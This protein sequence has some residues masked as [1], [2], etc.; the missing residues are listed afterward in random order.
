MVSLPADSAEGVREGRWERCQRAR[1]EAAE[2]VQQQ[3]QQQTRR[4][5]AYVFI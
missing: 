2:A 5:I 3:G 4:G 1:K